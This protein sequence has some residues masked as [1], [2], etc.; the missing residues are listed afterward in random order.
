MAIDLATEVEMQKLSCKWER[1]KMAHLLRMTMNDNSDKSE[2][3]LDEIKG[4]VH[5]TQNITLG[6]F[7]NATIS[8]LLKGSVKS[9]LYYKHVNVSVEPLEVHK[10]DGAKYCAVPG[11]TFLKPG[12]HRIHVMIKNLT[13]RNI[14]VNQGSKIA[15]MAAPNVMLAPQASTQTETLPAKNAQCSTVE[16]GE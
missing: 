2:F 6:P 14:T 5:L 13:V 1:V 12:S 7:E 4:S 11:Y 10:E 9:S 15:E 16:G 8:G 3:N